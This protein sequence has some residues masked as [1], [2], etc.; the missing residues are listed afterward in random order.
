MYVSSKIL[1][2]DGEIRQ[3]A[4]ISRG[5]LEKYLSNFDIEFRRKDKKSTNLVV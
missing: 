4:N 3:V 5:K 2:E 1:G